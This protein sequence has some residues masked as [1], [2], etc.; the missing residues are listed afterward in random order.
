MWH[1]TLRPGEHL[2]SVPADKTRDFD[3]IMSDAISELVYLRAQVEGAAQER[4]R[5]QEV[6]QRLRNGISDLAL[7]RP[8][9][10]GWLDLARA[11]DDLLQLVATRTPPPPEAQE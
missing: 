4:A 9:F 7:E 8:Y 2:W 6:E 3:C 10:S 5:L 1:K 11:C